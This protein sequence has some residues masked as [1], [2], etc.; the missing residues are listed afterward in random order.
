MDYFFW[1]LR[2]GDRTVVVDTGFEPSCGKRR[3]R[4]CV[5]TPHDALARLGIDPGSVEQLILT[6]FHYDHI[7]NVGMFPNA[8]LILSAAEY[9]FFTSPISQRFHFKEPVEGPEI[10]A[11]VAAADAGRVRL[12]D[13]QLEVAPGVTAI[14]V[15]GHAPGQIIVDVQTANRPVVLASDAVHL[16]EEL[17][18][19]RPFSVLVDLAGMYRAFDLLREREAQGAVVVPGHDPDVTSRFPA[20]ERD[21]VTV[22]YRLS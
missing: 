9:E 16:Y 13:D 8:E 11:I 20:V 4:T 1:I 15:G 21:G 17:E 10:D 6:H 3:G 12:V 7:G 5:T 14:V 18:K 22:A 2:G 19:D